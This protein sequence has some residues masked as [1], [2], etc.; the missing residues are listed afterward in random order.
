MNL[1]GYAETIQCLTKSRLVDGLPE[2]LHRTNCQGISIPKITRKISLYW[3]MILLQACCKRKNGL[4]R[5]LKI[6]K[7]FFIGY[8]I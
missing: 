7:R 4:A 5:H 3:N 6:S 8:W 2:V 1:F